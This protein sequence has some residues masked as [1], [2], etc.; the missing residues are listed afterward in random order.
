MNN[1]INQLFNELNNIQMEYNASISED[2]ISELLFWSE[3]L[4][5]K[6]NELDQEIWNEVCKR[7]QISNES[8]VSIS[9]GS[10]TFNKPITLINEG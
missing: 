7:V 10:L 2:K 4:Q 5:N 1:I 6:K 3:K 8:N 9:I